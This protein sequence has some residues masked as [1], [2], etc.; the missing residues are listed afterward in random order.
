MARRRYR[1]AC[2]GSR[3]KDRI[4][5]VNSAILQ[6]SCEHTGIAAVISADMLQHLGCCFGGVGVE[7]DHLAARVALN[8][9]DFQPVTDI[10]QRFADKR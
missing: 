2:F 10:F 5:L 3:Q 7:C 1:L 4:A 8:K 9:R 6:D